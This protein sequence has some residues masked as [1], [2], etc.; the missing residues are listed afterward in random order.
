MGSGGSAMDGGAL[1]DGGAASDAADAGS[2]GAV[3]ALYTPEPGLHVAVCSVIAYSTNPPTSGP[4]YPI[5]AA[6]KTY[7]S[8]VP[9][10][11]LV[12]SLEHGA[13]VVSYNCPGG[14]DADL[15][16]LQAFLAA[17]PADPLCVAP[18]QNRFIVTPDP[19]LDVP[20][21][22][23]AWGASLKAQ[24]LDLAALG[25]FIDAH[26]A[27]ASENF[28]FDGTD[29]TAAS[30]GIPADCGQPPADAGAD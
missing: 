12:H 24:C 8:P 18:L 4:H 16:A 11:F 9:R 20:F 13:V 22:A 17:R 19:L 14:C 6:F 7:T 29:V 21:A 30:A 25:A 3:E 15:A 23:A 26:Y 2:C 1:E 28:C 5:W 27:Q 10:G